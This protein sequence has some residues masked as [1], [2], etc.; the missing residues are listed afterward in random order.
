MV[1]YRIFCNAS[2]TKL[3]CAVS[4]YN[5][6][7]GKKGS[8]IFDSKYLVLLERMCIEL[9]RKVNKHREKHVNEKIRA[10]AENS[11]VHLVRLGPKT[12]KLLILKS[13]KKHTPR[14]LP[15]V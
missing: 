6:R 13:S 15:L 8:S 12:D 11:H 1:C 7:A 9:L 14:G 4:G 2:T 3:H 10:A 5:V